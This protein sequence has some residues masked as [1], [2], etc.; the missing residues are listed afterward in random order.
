MNV[1]CM[2]S[3]FHND[4]CWNWGIEA[5]AHMTYLSA[6]KNIVMQFGF[7]TY[8]I[9]GRFELI[10]CLNFWGV[11]LPFFPPLSVLAS[12]RAAAESRE[13]AEADEPGVG[14]A[15][16]K[17]ALRRPQEPGMGGV[18]TQRALPHI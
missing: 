13:Q 16:E 11:G 10:G 1:G 15:P 7:S 6:Q 3:L 2:P 18:Q 12:G 9:C 17:L 4:C 14:G 5:A 8:S